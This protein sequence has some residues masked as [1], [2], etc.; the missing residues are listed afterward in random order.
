MARLVKLYRMVER[1]DAAEA[2]LAADA[3]ERVVRVRAAEVVAAREQ[4]E[5][6]RAALGA[7]DR[8]GWL[9]AESAGEFAAVRVAGLA[10]LEAERKALHERALAVYRASR[11]RTEQMERVDE[12]ARREQAME[13]TRKSQ[14]EADD[15]FGARLGQRTHGWAAREPGAR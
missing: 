11:M 6:A 2:R 5:R 13:E 9:A 14:A 8:S 10:A 1:I 3:A 4:R 12:K 15:R 7:G